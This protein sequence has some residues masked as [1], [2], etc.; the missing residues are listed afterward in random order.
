MT[1]WQARR[2]SRTFALFLV[3]IS[4]APVVTVARSSGA[5][6][7]SNRYQATAVVTGSDRRSRP[8]GFARCLRE[9]L[10]KVSGEPRLSHDPRVDRLAA[11]ADLFVASFDYV[12]QLAAYH[13]HDDQGTYD[14][15][16]N[17]TVHFVPALIDKALADLG[18][19]PWRGQ[20]PVIMPVL[21]VRG[22]TAAYLLSAESPAG[23]DQRVAF[24][25]VARDL[26][27]Q[28]RFPTD[29]DFAAWG[30]TVGQFPSPQVAPSA[31]EAVV[32]GTLA[33]KRAVPGWAGSWRMRYHGIDYAWGIHGVNFDE[34]FRDIV[35]GVVRVASG[36]GAPE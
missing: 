4:V 14:R 16:F 22:Y 30:V 29:A 5:Q 1:D 24:A 17:L 2:R 12:D 23:A 6:D 21:M 36:H 10:V 18:E 32:A 34:A 8:T 7:M 31:D 20:R 27:M 11:E 33:F 3:M 25:D 28:V 35:R 9:V 19:Q 13:H 26:G 15:P